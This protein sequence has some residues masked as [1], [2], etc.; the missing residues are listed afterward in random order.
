MIDATP[1]IGGHGETGMNAEASFLVLNG[2][3]SVSALSM[4]FK[5]TNGQWENNN[6]VSVYFSIPDPENPGNYQTAMTTV[7]FHNSNGHASTVYHKN[8]YGTSTFDESSVDSLTN[9]TTIN[10]QEED[11]GPWIVSEDM[12]EDFKSSKSRLYG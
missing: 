10:Y 6:W 11:P 12:A 2:Y 4:W 5:L 8:F 1:I 7:Q 3:D 9:F